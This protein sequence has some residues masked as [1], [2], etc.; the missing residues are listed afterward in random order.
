MLNLKLST[1]IIIVAAFICFVLFLVFVSVL[2]IN[3]NAQSDVKR[4]L[5]QISSRNYAG[6]LEF[7]SEKARAQQS[8]FQEAMKFHF[9]LELA[10]LE[11]FNLMDT[12]RY[13]IKIKRDSMWLPV[14]TANELG[15]S[16]KLT[17]Q[18]DTNPILEYL[19]KPGP[20]ALNGFVTMTR[21]NGKWKISSINIKGSKLE[22]IFNK[23]L[24]RVAAGKYISATPEEIT[25]RPAFLK[26][27]ELDPLE[28]KILARDLQTALEIIDKDEG[29]RDKKS[30]LPF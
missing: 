20:D 2:G 23:I 27:K 13:S 15:I 18:K 7:Y 24:P 21:E 14:L 3:N 4:F 22:N 11:H 26:V 29:S 1:K 5:Q 17:P 8:S 16:V 30:K 6:V 25:L 12:Q 10:L 9:A 19:S 28:R